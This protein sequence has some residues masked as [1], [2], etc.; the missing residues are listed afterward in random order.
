VQRQPVRT[1]SALPGGRS[2]HGGDR[3]RHLLFPFDFE[4]HLRSK[5]FVALQLTA[6]HGVADRVLDY[7]LWV[8]PTFFEKLANGRCL[9]C[10]HPCTALTQTC[11]WSLP[12]VPTDARLK[13]GRRETALPTARSLALGDSRTTISAR[14]AL[15]EG[16]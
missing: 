14:S 8:T 4:G 5:F 1:E 9:T 13:I 15:S 10:L 3:R 2:Q 6:L 11:C 12:L 16:T 7:A